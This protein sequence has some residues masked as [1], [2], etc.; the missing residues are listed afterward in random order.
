[1]ALLET[2]VILGRVFEELQFAV[3]ERPDLADRAADIEITAFQHLAGRDDAASPDGHPR[4]HHS[5]VHH[6]GSH[7]DQ[8]I[9]LDS[10]GM[11][12]DLVP[13][14]DI[15]ADHGRLAARTEAAVVSDVNDG[16][17]LNAGAGADADVL[18]VA[19]NDAHRPDRAVFADFDR[20]DD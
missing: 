14:R 10:A 3:V 11:Q 1:M 7:A 9:V 18:N 6:D 17:I 16:S 15:V 20:A 13:N 5:L 12:D 19:P 8:A 2:A 4:L